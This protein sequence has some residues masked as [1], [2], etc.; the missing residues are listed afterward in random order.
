MLR[1]YGWIPDRPDHRDLLYKI[2]KPKLTLPQ[3]VDLTLQCSPVENQGQL[4]SCTANA[5]VGNLEFLELKENIP[6]LDLSRLFIYYNERLIEGTVKEDSGATLR[7]GIKSLVKAGYCSEKMWEYD[8]KKFA[9]KPSIR[10]YLEAR[11]HRIKEYRSLLTQNDLLTCLAEG[12]PF[13]FGISIYESFESDKVAKTGIIPMPTLSERNLGGHAVMAVGYDRTKQVFI[14]RNSWG[15]GWGNKGYFTLP[16]NYLEKLG[17][18][19]W[20]IR[21]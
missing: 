18:D 19:Y 11:H 9:Q 14:V 8:I 10:C 15:I 17:S 2:I 7:D 6:Y 1:K 16:F 20:T 21:K 3:K 4:G 12:Y 13:V 5:L